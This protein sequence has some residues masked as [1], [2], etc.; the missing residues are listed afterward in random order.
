MF[1]G[2]RTVEVTNRPNGNEIPFNMKNKEIKVD[3]RHG[4]L[5]RAADAR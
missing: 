5:R 2:S 1:D 3:R 4:D